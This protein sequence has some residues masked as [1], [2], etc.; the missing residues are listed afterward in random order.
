L[1]GDLTALD[2]TGVRERKASGKS[3]SPREVEILELVA[4]GLTSPEIATRLFVT[5]ETVRE[6]MRRIFTKLGARTRAHAVAIAREEAN[7]AR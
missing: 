3:L 1:L 5:T 6:H 2:V 4:E 7:R